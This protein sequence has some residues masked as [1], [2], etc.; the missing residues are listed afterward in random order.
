MKIWGK[1][2]GLKENLWSPIKLFGSPIKIWGSATKIRGPDG[3]LGSPMIIWGG[4]VNEK[5]GLSNEIT[6]NARFL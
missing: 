1:H 2:V 6:P 3:K 4:V 5:L